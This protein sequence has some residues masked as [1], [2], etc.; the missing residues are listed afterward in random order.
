MTEKTKI[1]L[2]CNIFDKLLTLS[3]ETL[4]KLT[5]KYTV[6]VN[7]NQLD[8]INNITDEN[9]KSQI[10]ALIKTYQIRLKGVF[11]FDGGGGLG[12]NDEG[13][14]Y[15]SCFLSDEAYDILFKVEKWLNANTKKKP[16]V[17][18]P[19]PNRADAVLAALA[20]NCNCILVT[21]DGAGKKPGLIQAVK[22]INCTVWTFSELL[23]NL[24]T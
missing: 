2:D 10:V 11:T 13:Y 6:S 3:D 12:F 21:E 16:Q 15:D 1:M 9:K 19:Y 22:S 18:K 8:E 5:N 4:R 24:H 7:K 17:N 20:D 14:L 23:D